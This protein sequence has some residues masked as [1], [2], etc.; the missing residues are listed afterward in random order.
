MPGREGELTAEAPFGF[1]QG[2]R[3]AP[4]ETAEEQRRQ[5][6]KEAEEADSSGWLKPPTLGMIKFEEL[7]S[8]LL[9][10]EGFQVVAEG[11]GQGGV[12]EGVVDAGAQQAQLGAGV[13][14]LTLE[15]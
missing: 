3:F 12:L 14:V 13:E 9:E 8:L 5:G 2:L 6:S 7:F 4:T 15:G 10:L 11:R 1:A